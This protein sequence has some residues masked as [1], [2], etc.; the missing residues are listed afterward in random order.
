[1]SNGLSLLH[2]VSTIDDHQILVLTIQE[3]LHLVTGYFF[4]IRYNRVIDRLLQIEERQ[5]HY[6]KGHRKQDR[7]DPFPFKGDYLPSINQQYP[8]LA[9]TMIWNETYSILIGQYIPGKFREWGY[10]MWDSITLEQ[11][12]RKELLMQQWREYW[13]DRDPRELV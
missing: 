7:R 5:E 4:G 12:G 10:V 13:K 8:P 3:R 6:S 2:T 1:M 9:W 11:I